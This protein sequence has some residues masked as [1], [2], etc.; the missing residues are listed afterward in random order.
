MSPTPLLPPSPGPLLD[1]A[2]ILAIQLLVARHPNLL[3][4]DDVQRIRPLPSLRAARAIVRLIDMLL[5]ELAHY[6]A[7]DDLDDAG[8]AL[9]AHHA[10]DPV[11][12]TAGDDDDIPF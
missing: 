5:A 11:A 1:S 3:L 7:L 4:P 12:T 6:S 10:P 8:P 2:L 9:D